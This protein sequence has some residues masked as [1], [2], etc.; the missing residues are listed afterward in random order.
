MAERT[1]TTTPMAA[2]TS[3]TGTNPDRKTSG[4]RSPMGIPS[5]PEKTANSIAIRAVP[6]APPT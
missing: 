3:I 5:V 1:A 2:A 4:V 6:T